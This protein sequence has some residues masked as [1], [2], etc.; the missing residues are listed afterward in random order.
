MLLTVFTALGCISL[1]A[2]ADTTSQTAEL[3]SDNLRVKITPEGKFSIGLSNGFKSDGEEDFIPITEGI[4]RNKY[5]SV[6][7]IYCDEYIHPFGNG[8]NQKDI[9]TDLPETEN[10]KQKQTTYYLAEQSVRIVEGDGADSAPAVELKY[11]VTNTD[12]REHKIGAKIL[13]DA[14]YNVP[15]H[16]PGHD[17]IDTQTELSGDDIPSYWYTYDPNEMD[18]PVVKGTLWNDPSQK[19]DRVHFATWGHIYYED[20][21]YNLNY[22]EKIT[23]NA[24]CVVW[25][26]QSL[27]P[28]ETREFVTY[29]GI[30]EITQELNPPLAVSVFAD[31]TAERTDDGF[32]PVNITA[33][34]KNI[35]TAKAVNVC[36]YIS[37]ISDTLMNTSED[38]PYKTSLFD[39]EVNAIKVI[40]WKVELP[41]WLPRGNYQ[42]TISVEADNTGSKS[43]ARTIHIPD[44]KTNDNRITWFPKEIITDSSYADNLCFRNNRINFLNKIDSQMSDLSYPISNVY[45]DFLIDGLKP[46]TQYNIINEKNKHWS[47]ACYGMSSVVSLIKTKNITPGKWQEH[48]SC[49][50]HL[51]PPA[52]NTDKRVECLINFYH[53]AQFLP[54]IKQYQDEYAR[55]FGKIDYSSDFDDSHNLEYAV[56][57]IGKVKQGG[58]PVMLGFTWY[59]VYNDFPEDLKEKQNLSYYF[60]FIKSIGN[61]WIEPNG[62]IIDFSKAGFISTNGNYFD[63]E[64]KNHCYSVIGFDK[65]GLEVKSGEKKYIIKKIIS[66][67][68]MILGYDVE[69]GNY[70]VNGNNYK[71]K[72]SVYDPN[73]LIETYLYITEN[74]SNWYYEHMNQVSN[75]NNMQIFKSQNNKEYKMLYLVLSDERLINI[76]NPETY[77]NNNILTEYTHDTFSSNLENISGLETPNNYYEIHGYNINRNDEI[78]IV[79][80]IGVTS[81]NENNSS[82]TITLPP[83][84]PYYKI[85]PSWGKIDSSLKIGD[86]YY[87]VKSDS[88]D[89]ATGYRS[90]ELNLINKSGEYRLGITANNP[91]KNLPWCTIR[92]SGNGKTASTLKVV[93]DG[94]VMIS[95]N[96]NGIQAEASNIDMLIYNT[97][98]TATFSTDYPSVKFM[99]V[100][101]DTLG[102]YVD[103]DSD[104]TYETIIADSDGTQYGDSN[105]N[106]ELPQEGG[107]AKTQDGSTKPESPGETPRESTQESTEQTSTI[108]SQGEPQQNTPGTENT[109]DNTEQSAPQESPAAETLQT[110][111][112][113]VASTDYGFVPWIGAGIIA[114]VA[115]AAVIIMLRKR[116]A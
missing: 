84:Q 19:P 110:S 3:R 86:Y 45:F 24:V 51:Y 62:N 28:G 74:Y 87:I 66:K 34:I 44:Q 9:E 7:G 79:P 103:T 69:M 16:M 67:S 77:E 114:A 52:Y 23:D 112:E 108:Q 37:F 78:N 4:E 97:P 82:A 116:K 65:N 14:P 56:S 10:I 101:D 41:R 54:D 113:P 92:I 64:Y 13:L 111:S 2:A 11:K 43:I 63:F 20:L 46:A 17:P 94:M 83:N 109:A 12:K 81:D 59:S 96:I 115:A 93:S 98:L 32:N 8:S 85:D 5:F 70:F 48:A 60:D 100:D 95:D 105:E 61:T 50:Y 42:Y 35:G 71:Y 26:K 89:S 68:H 33:Y 36:S 106:P 21:D 80:T 76:K 55:T 102:V 30:G 22:G 72:I 31:S 47:G 29:L 73:K 53:I 18:K 15:F 99:A 38:T 39:L 90:G 27:A 1:N 40:N 88:A 107:E 25:D 75:D 58:F 57:E 104:G 91:I 6:A 49:A